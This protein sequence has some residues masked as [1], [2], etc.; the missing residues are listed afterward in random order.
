MRKIPFKDMVAQAHRKHK[1]LLSVN[2][3]DYISFRSLVRTFSTAG[4]PVIAQFSSRIFKQYR[5]EEIVGWRKGLNIDE[6]WLHLDHCADFELIESCARAGFD[7]VMFD[8]SDL[9]LSS[10]IAK[11]CQISKRIRTVAP[12][13]LLE[14]EI[15]HVSGVEDGFGSDEVKDT[16][17]IDEEVVSFYHAV[18]PD[19]LAVG[20]GNMHGHYKGDEVFNLDLL[21]KVSARLSQVPLVLHG[22][23]GMALDLVNQLVQWGHIKINISTDL[24]KF[25]MS[26]MAD[27]IQDKV[28]LNSPMAVNARSNEKLDH[29]FEALAEKYKSCLL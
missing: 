10:N 28:N 2:V 26:L 22:G 27:L 21:E 3:F 24:K 12:D 9:D 5:P 17:L 6:V 1:A 8:G 18:R 25:W 23:S 19:L 4:Q 15:G 20:F 14:C 29:F 7:S 11:S 13:C 16:D